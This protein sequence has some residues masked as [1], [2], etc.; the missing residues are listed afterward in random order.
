MVKRLSTMQETRVQSLGWEGNGSPLQGYCLENPMDG[1]AWQATVHGVAKSRTRLSDF[2]FISADFGSGPCCS[3][4]L[5]PFFLLKAATFFI[6]QVSLLTR[7]KWRSDSQFPLIFDIFLKLVFVLLNH[8]MGF[9]W[10]QG[11]YQNKHRDR[12]QFGISESPNNSSPP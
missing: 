7:L 8:G 2:T 3:S 1:G 11:W 9:S 12:C 4:F 10:G 5:P 6:S